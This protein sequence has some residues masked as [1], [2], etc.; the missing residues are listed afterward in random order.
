MEISGTY[1]VG[2]YSRI[3]HPETETILR[4]TRHMSHQPSRRTKVKCPKS[5][6]GVNAN[7]KV[8]AR[9]IAHQ[10]PKTTSTS[11]VHTKRI[12]TPSLQHVQGVRLPRCCGS[13]FTVQVMPVTGSN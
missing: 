13:H 8:A 3:T 12:S 6:A 9:S 1:L 5:Q 7:I 10:W 4:L 11:P 2:S